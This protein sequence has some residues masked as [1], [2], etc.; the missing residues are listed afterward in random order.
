MFW[1]RTEALQPLFKAHIKIEDFPEEAGQTDATL[2]HCIERL[3]VL[4]AK[5]SGLNTIILRDSKSMSWSRW[6]FE[7]YLLRNQETHSCNAG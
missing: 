3:F 1:A 4:V 2:A 6:H 5:R 7:Q